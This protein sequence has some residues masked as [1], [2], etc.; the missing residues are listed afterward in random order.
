MSNFLI[1]RYYKW[2][3]NI[4]K[5]ELFEHTLILKLEVAFKQLQFSLS[6]RG[7]P[8]VN[9]EFLCLEILFKNIKKHWTIKLKF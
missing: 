2:S 8:T 6:K 9:R 7:I 5:L 1:I 3:R 4:Q